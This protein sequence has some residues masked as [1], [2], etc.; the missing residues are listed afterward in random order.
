VLGVVAPT[1]PNNRTDTGGERLDE[2]LQPGSG[3]WSGSAGLNL[4]LPG[5]QGTFL[6]S[7]LGRLNGENDHGYRYGNAVLYN[8]GFYTPR[9]QGWSATVQANGRT[10]AR[11]DLG[12]GVE[13]QHTGGT[14]VYLSPGLRWQSGFGVAVEGLVQI[15]VIESLY[16]IQDEHTTAHIA[17]SM[18]H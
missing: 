10:A 5:H 11:D 9:R 3:A 2:H 15:P 13:G 7:V 8:A 1:G 14:V 12:E 16:G 17:L 4:T 6:A 18:D